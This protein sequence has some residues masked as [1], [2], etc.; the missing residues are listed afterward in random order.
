VILREIRRRGDEGLTLVADELLKSS[1][2]EAALVSASRK[3]FGTWPTA[4][5]ASDVA[6]DGKGLAKFARF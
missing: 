3:I 1:E 6:W 4:L 5:R 2:E